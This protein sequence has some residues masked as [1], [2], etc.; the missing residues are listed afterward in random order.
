MQTAVAAERLQI[1]ESSVAPPKAFGATRE[2]AGDTPAT[3]TLRLTQPPLRL[4]L[5]I[6]RLDA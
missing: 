6:E 2:N 1:F 4:A 5:C 3:T